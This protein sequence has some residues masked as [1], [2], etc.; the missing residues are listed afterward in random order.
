MKKKP[1]FISLFAGC[2]GSSLGYKWA[3]FKELLA[4]DIDKNATE[5]FKLNFPSI[6][7]WER[8][9]KE[10]TGK[11]ILDFC[12][13]KKGELDLLDASPPCQGFSTAGKR[14]VLD[15]RND[16]F[17]EFVRLIKEL[18]SKVFI[19]ENVS[20]LVKGKMKG[21]FIEIMKELKVLPYKVKCKLMNSM[22]Y[23]VPQSRPR[24]IWIGMK[25]NEPSFP[26]PSDKVI[27]VK[28]AI[29]NL[30]EKQD[31]F[32]SNN[33]IKA[34]KKNKQGQRL[35]SYNSGPIKVKSNMPI[36]TLTRAGRRKGGW[37]DFHYKYPRPL[38]INEM[39]ILSSF[40]INFK[41]SGNRRDKID[42]IGNSVPPKFMEAIAKNIK[43]QVFQ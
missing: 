23:G 18:E 13:I 30:N 20:G 5:T 37:N 33:I 3:G 9:I 22:Y 35:T 41:L 40:P 42:V 29:G 31:A 15:P 14:N 39:K 6:P 28:E 43:E 32:P 1:T 34:W 8:D 25:N 38:T 36:H 27:S 16:L 2:G 19:M 12:N 17:L 7:Y 10:I 21:R 11:E 24:L 26:L 4:I